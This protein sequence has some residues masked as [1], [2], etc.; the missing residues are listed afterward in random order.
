M[1]KYQFISD[2]DYQHLDDNYRYKEVDLFPTNIRVKRDRT[3]RF[4]YK[5]DTTQST[6]NYVL[7]LDPK[8]EVAIGNLQYLE[9]N[10]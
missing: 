5:K 2:K 8:N 7:H 6:I 4:T 3:L 10:L 1:E 9:E